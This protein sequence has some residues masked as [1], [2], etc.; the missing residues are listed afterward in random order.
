MSISVKNAGG[1]ESIKSEVEA[2]SQLIEEIRA[3]LV[4][5]ATPANATADKIL[6]GYSAYVGQ[7]LVTGSLKL[8]TV[9]GV[10]VENLKLSSEKV[11]LMMDG[12]LPVEVENNSAFIWDGKIHYLTG[13]SHYELGSGG[14]TKFETTPLPG[15]TKSCAVVYKNELHALGCASNYTS[16]K[17][18]YKWNGTSWTKVGEL[19]ISFYGGA[20]CVYEDELYIFC[21]VSSSAANTFYKFNGA[22][23]TQVGT[24]PYQFYYGDVVVYN[25]EIHMLG[26]LTTEKYKSHYKW[27]GASWTKVG[28]LPEEFYYKP[29]IAHD[30]KI[31]AVSSNYFTIMEYDGQGWTTRRMKGG[32]LHGVGSYMSTTNS[33]YADMVIYENKVNLMSKRRVILGVKRY[34]EITQEGEQA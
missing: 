3:A 21:Q 25:D 10:P 7:Q 20:T 31:I 16:N 5:K 1:G 13:T 24:L 14:W 33:D 9:D 28:E 11:D 29:A 26:S 12:T 22:T 27:N 2:Q 23:W 30:G 17:F 34:K 19:P 15:F 4:G 18:H 8:P 6:E 32:S